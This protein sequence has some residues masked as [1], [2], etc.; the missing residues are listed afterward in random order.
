MTDILIPD[1]ESFQTK[2][3]MLIEGG[4]EHLHVIADFD[5]TLTKAF[6]DG[7]PM[8]SLPSILEEE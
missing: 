4:A 6:I 8:T 3:A 1:P 5:R 2:L 7:K